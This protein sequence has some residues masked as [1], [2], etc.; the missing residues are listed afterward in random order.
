MNDEDEKL[1]KNLG[2]TLSTRNDSKYIFK[3]RFNI[4][5][6]K[7]DAIKDLIPNF[8]VDKPVKFDQNLMIKAIQYGM[9][10]TI[11]YRADY[12]RWRGGMERTI[13]PMVIG[14]NKNTKNLLIRAWHLEGYS[15]SQKRETKR[16]WRL[17]KAS[18]M[19]WMKFTGEFFRLPPQG[20]KMNDRVMTLQTIKAADFSE[21]RRNQNKLLEIGKIELEGETK[22]GDKPIITKIQVKNTGSIID[23][24]NPTQNQYVDKKNIK[25]N[26]ISIL[27]PINTNNSDIIAVIGAIGTINKNVDIYLDNN[28]K[29][30]TFKTIKAFTGAEFNT[31]RQVNNISEFDLYTFVKK[32]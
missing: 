6:G 28:T 17:F 2:L 7:Y 4:N 20:Y 19:F 8:P 13:Y 22:F 9:V 32:L 3:K 12:S 15:V 10:L 14:I 27:K 25:E 1:F 29:L 31:N 30:G 23:L 16:V 26:K 24:K 5:E 11:S 21:I 18:N